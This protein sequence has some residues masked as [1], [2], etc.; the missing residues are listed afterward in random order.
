MDYFLELNRIRSMVAGKSRV[1]AF[2]LETEV[3][4]GFLRNER[5]IAISVAT[6]QGKVDILT[7]SYE[8]NDQLELLGNFSRIVEEYKPEI[9][10]GYNHTSYDV[11]LI[12]TNTVDMPFYEKLWGL[13]YYLGTSYL[14]DMMYVCALHGATINGE[15]RIRSLQKVV[16]APEYKN[17]D[18][19]RSKEEAEITGMNKGEA[20]MWLWKNSRE[21]FERYCRGDVV[22]LLELYRYILL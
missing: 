3:R 19:L 4:D 17:L 11:S 20:I 2:D 12:N 18:L 10:I 6:L 1:M 16:N 7:G 14:L 15:Y 5:I 13:K 22:D 9:I 8:K 21:S